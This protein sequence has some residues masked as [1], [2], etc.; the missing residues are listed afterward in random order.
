M[1]RP[2]D[3]SIAMT[4]AKPAVEWRS[5]DRIATMGHALLDGRCRLCAGP[6]AYWAICAGCHEDLPWISAA[7]RRCGLPL[8][9]GADHCA[10]CLSAPPVFNRSVAVWSYTNAIVPLIRR[11]KLYDDWA[12]GRLLSAMA[13]AQLRA[14]RW[15]CPAPLVAMPLHAQRL[16]QRGFNQ[17]ELIARWL[18]GPLIKRLVKR[19]Q[20]TP[21]QRQLNAA[22]R[23]NN[24]RGA[25]ALQASP[26]QALTLVDD[27]MTTGASLNA[28]AQCLREGGTQHIEVIVLARAI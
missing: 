26:P 11:F 4:A 7:C 6:S 14:R 15:S 8:S 16:R 13:A 27:V 25:F 20:N 2:A 24:L 18:G 17:A 1:T 3:T 23:E 19:T 9:S 10:G 28:L 22:T 21:S 5:I 12:A